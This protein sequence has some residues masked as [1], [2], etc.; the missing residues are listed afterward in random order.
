MK[1][2]TIFFAFLVARPSAAITLD[3]ALETATEHSHELKTLSLQSEM[4]S[5]A[6]KEAFAGFLPRLELTGRHL[7]DEQFHEIETNFGGETF[8]MP[9][10]QPYS[11]L[12][13]TARWNLFDGLKTTSS[14]RA[15]SFAQKAAEANLTR[16]QELKRT[17]IRTLFYQAL[18]AQALVTVTDQNVRSLESHL[19]DIK[20][21]QRTGIATRYDSLRVEVQLED[22][23]TEKLAAE[24][25]TTSQRATLFAAI[26]VR[27]DG[28]RLEGQLPTDFAKIDLARIKFQPQMRQDRFVLVANRDRLESLAHVKRATWYPAVSLFGDYEW[29]NNIN[30]SVSGDDARFKSAYAVG[31]QLNWTIFAGG[32]DYASQQQ[33]IL[34]QEVAQEALGNFDENAPVVLEEAKRRFAYDLR[35]YKAKIGSVRKAEEAVRLAKG[36]LRAGTLTNTEVLDA[37]VDL[38][39]ANASAIRS[40]LDA[41]QHL[42]ELELAAGHA[43][44]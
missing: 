24:N 42:G 3:Q 31:V 6:K 37:V 26:G 17:E 29:Y 40:Q 33:S 35:S 32:A 39:R 43:L 25:A 8:V 10:I 12:G 23:R 4:T 21:R 1:R 30:D 44:L 5:W 27:D 36:G 14:L 20:V 16:A 18:G 38:N 7:F 11:A 9:A 28:K 13:L 19:N 34:A 41:I 2:L 15:A 22:A